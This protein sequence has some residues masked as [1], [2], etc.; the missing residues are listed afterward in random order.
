MQKRADILG[1]LLGWFA[2]IAQFLL[3]IQ[4][5]QAEVLESIIR[6]FS[7]FTI[8][9][10]L[11]ATIFF[12]VRLTGFKKKPFLFL[13]S[14]GALTAITSFILIVGLVYQTVLR[15]IWEPTGL[16]QLVDELLHTINP[17]FVLVYW[18][19]FVEKK[20]LVIKALLSWLWYPII[21]LVYTLIRG[22]F[23]NFYPYPFLNVD[24]LGYTRVL[25]NVTIIVAVTLTIFA[26]LLNVGRWL[27]QKRD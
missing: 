17:L 6:F 20:D 25:L 24:N 13:W 21:F 4:N 14:P 2:I 11:L 27:L 7:Y 5:R 26:L 16:Q 8:L 23:T 22:R 19:L 15:S 18:I 1:L 3:M 9:T 10:N 12:T